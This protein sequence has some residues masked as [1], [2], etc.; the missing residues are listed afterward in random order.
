M[1]LYIVG[2]IV[3]LVLVAS[4]LHQILTVGS[5]VILGIAI[6]FGGKLLVKRYGKK[7]SGKFC[8]NCGDPQHGL[9]RCNRCNC[10]SS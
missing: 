3:A 1:P 5:I 6:Y 9:Q 8:S 10:A 2:A 7:S 4:Y